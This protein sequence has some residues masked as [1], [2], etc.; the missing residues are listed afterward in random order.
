MKLICLGTVSSET[1]NGGAS[2]FATKNVLS[3]DN[4]NGIP[5]GGQVY[6]CRTTAQADS[7]HGANSQCDLVTG[8][9]G[10]VP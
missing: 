7:F 5:F 8:G 9:D 3:D 10:I 1:K 6:N 2:P 4:A